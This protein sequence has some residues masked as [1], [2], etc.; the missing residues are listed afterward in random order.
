MASINT[1]VTVNVDRQT[2]AVTVAGYSLAMFLGKHKA[3]TQRYK[4]YSD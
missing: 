3:F 2:S 1:A 4:V